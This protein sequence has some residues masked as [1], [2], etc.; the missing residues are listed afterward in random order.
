MKF[1]PFLLQPEFVERVWGGKKIAQFWQRDA[2][3]N[4]GELWCAY[5]TNVIASGPWRGQRLDAVLREHGA[6]LLGERVVAEYGP[7]LPLLA[8]LIESNQWSSVQVHPDDAYARSHEAASGYRGKNEAWVILEAEPQASI[9]HGPQKTTTRAELMA[10]LDAGLA[11]DVLRRTPARRGDVVHIPSGTIHAFSDG[12]FLFEI[13]QRSD[14]TYR[15]YDF[16]RGRELHL[17]KA[18]A[19]CDFNPSRQIK[20]AKAF[21]QGGLLIATPFFVLEELA[22]PAG[23]LL[24]AAADSFA[25]AT[26]IEGAALPIGA[27]WF[28]PKGQSVAAA[29][30]RW[31]K[32]YIP[33]AA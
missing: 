18:F 4:Y 16:G 13:Q 28:M 31:F 8:K 7:Q 33:G 29:P 3:I 10:A 20:V 6:A 11:L 26:Y 27:T 25:L 19:V 22:L 30:G 15:M 17:E 14:L 1:E 24:R 21:E 12:I 32:T 23:A 5:D 9:A 2:A